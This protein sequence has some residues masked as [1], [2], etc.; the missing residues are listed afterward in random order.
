MWNT[1]AINLCVTVSVF[2]NRPCNIRILHHS[3]EVSRQWNS[4][5]QQTKENEFFFHPYRSCAVSSP[6]NRMSVEQQ[7]RTASS[8]GRWRIGTERKVG[9]RWWLC[10]GY[11]ISENPRLGATGGQRMQ[12]CCGRK[13]PPARATEKETAQPNPEGKQSIWSSVTPKSN[14]G[15][16][17]HRINEEGLHWI[18]YEHCESICNKKLHA[19]R[20]YLLFEQSRALN[21]QRQKRS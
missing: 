21:S 18:N 12:T 7:R 19:R 16:K 9:S 17:K 11:C 3:Q 20:K 2:G 1:P 10:E 4:E 15:S 13:E 14:W 6:M 8:L 5:A